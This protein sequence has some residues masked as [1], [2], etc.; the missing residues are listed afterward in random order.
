MYFLTSILWVYNIYKLML[1]FFDNKNV[2]KKKELLSYGIYFVVNRIIATYFNTPITLTLS[3]IISFLLISFNYKVK[4]KKR[5]LATILISLVPICVEVAVMQLIVGFN[6]QWFVKGEY[7]FKYLFC[8]VQLILY[9]VTLILGKFKNIKNG[10]KVSITYWCFITFIPTISLYIIFL[11]IYVENIAPIYTSIALLGVLMLNVLTF[12]LYDRITI[13]HIERTE[14]LLL[15]QQNKYYDEQFEVMNSS[16]KATRAIKH[17]LNNHM[18]IIS[19]LVQQDK[20]Q[21][22][23]HY[24]S[25]IKESYNENDKSVKTGNLAIDSVLNF[26]LQ[27]AYQQNVKV[28]LDIQIPDK[29]EIP[30]FDIVTLLGNL[31]DNALCALYK[32]EDNRVLNIQIKYDRG[33]IVIKIENT[34]NGM[35]LKKGN[36]ML[37]TKKDQNNHGIGLENVERVVNKY[38]GIL[39]I[40]YS[41]TVFSVTIFLYLNN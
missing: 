30:S 37:T 31:L 10:E 21:E 36:R 34:F 7:E 12:Y 3:N 28:S 8:I 15:E 29:I 1:V 35:V 25:K 33:R 26:K 38:E 16:I 40:E 13:A 4:F 32:L 19:S 41:E 11:L 14:K 6:V 39:D 22:V 24:L 9:V 18:A 17:D 5:I 27:D 2:N 20:A 23:L